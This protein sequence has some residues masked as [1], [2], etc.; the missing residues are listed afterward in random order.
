M[1]I[2]SLQSTSMHMRSSS[3]LSYWYRT[4]LARESGDEA[5]YAGYVSGIAILIFHI[6]KAGMLMFKDCVL[7]QST[8]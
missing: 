3:K 1:L 8:N 4:R 5:S 6:S 2:L 7:K